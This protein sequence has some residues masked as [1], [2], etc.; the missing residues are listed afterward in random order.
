MTAPSPQAIRYGPDGFPAEN[1][2]LGWQILAWQLEYLNQPD[3]PDAGSPWRYT[4]EQLKF[5]L[6]WYAIDDHGRFV[7][8]RGCL[9]RMK[10][11][12]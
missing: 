4:N 2:T 8:R 11:W 5:L 3:G 9:R 12:G 7:Y 1:R 6:W 10:G